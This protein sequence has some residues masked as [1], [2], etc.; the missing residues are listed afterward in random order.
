MGSLGRA[1]SPGRCEFGLICGIIRVLHSFKSIL[2]GIPGHVVRDHAVYEY[3]MDELLRSE[4][5]VIGN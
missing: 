1:S 4:S 3:G 2:V 5:T